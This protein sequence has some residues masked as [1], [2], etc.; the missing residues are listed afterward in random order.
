MKFKVLK[1]VGSP[2][3]LE[4]FAD[5]QTRGEPFAAWAGPVPSE[6]SREKSEV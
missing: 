1:R 3:T 5:R 6:F 4:R 2:A